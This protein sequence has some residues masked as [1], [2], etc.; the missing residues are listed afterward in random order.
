METP[1][2]LLPNISG[3]T[4]YLFKCIFTSTL[5]TNNDGLHYDI[6]YMY[7]A[8]LINFTQIMLLCPLP[9]PLNPHLFQTTPIFYSHVFLYIRI[10]T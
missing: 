5:I 4:Y 2:S 7:I 8:Y 9:T 3:Y 1:T 6:S 10:C